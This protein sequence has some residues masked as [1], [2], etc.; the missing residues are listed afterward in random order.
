VITGRGPG[1]PSVT[2]DMVFTLRPDA[3]SDPAGPAFDLSAIRRSEAIIDL[4]GAR[5]LLRPRAIHDPAIVALSVLAADVDSHEGGAPAALARS[6]AARV[7]AAAGVAGAAVASAAA[8]P[9]QAQGGSV[10]AW[11]HVA[12][13]AA[14]VAAV[15][16]IAGSTGFVVAGA[17]GRIAR[18]PAGV[19]KPPPGR[20]RNRPA[21]GRCLIVRPGPPSGHRTR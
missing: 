19:Q 9:T 8:A 4:L 21:T 7:A 18:L 14:T 1:A 17:L 11:A 6:H 3:R 20:R 16:G 15:A 2:L 13:V 10:G 5:R 12:A